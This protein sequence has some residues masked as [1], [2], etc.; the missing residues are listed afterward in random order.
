M[1]KRKLNAGI[2]QSPSNKIYLSKHLF[3][4]KADEP[5]SRFDEDR[6]WYTGTDRAAHPAMEDHQ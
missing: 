1:F 6:E 5:V 2:V 4:F 3:T